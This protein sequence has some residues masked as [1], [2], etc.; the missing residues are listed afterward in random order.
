MKNAM[1]HEPF[2]FSQALHLLKNGKRLA[3]SGWN[4]K[5]M[6]IF[7]VPGSRFKVNRAPL[8]EIYPE[9]TEIDYCPHIDMRTADDKIVPWVASQTEIMSDDWV[10]AK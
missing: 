1:I 10:E 7:L 3:R 4:D 2:N 6:F 5:N 9:G 8:L